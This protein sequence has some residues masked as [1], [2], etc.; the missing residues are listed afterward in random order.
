MPIALL[1]PPSLGKPRATARA[2]LLAQALTNELGEQVTIEVPSSYA[3]LEQRALFG[4]AHMVWAPASVAARLEPTA[5]AIFTVIRSG[6]G[7]YR[8]A[9]IA[10]KQDDVTLERL[11]GLR[12]AWVDPL[13]FGGYLL[14]V[15]HLRKRGID[16]D[17]T[18]VSQHFYGSHPDALAAVVA[19]HAHVSA[20][21]VPGSGEAELR[22]AL[23][24]HVGLHAAELTA[25]AITDGIPNDAM[26]FTSALGPA[27]ADAIARKLFSKD[28]GFRAPTFLLAAME[29]D[30]FVRA[31]PGEYGPLLHLIRAPGDPA[32]QRRSEAPPRRSEPPPPRRT[33]PPPKRS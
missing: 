30:A 17:R 24:M 13:S 2:E 8:S 19:G 1:L 20:V 4:T 32:A 18:F 33:E 9:I 27:R 21:T 16:P 11:N 10:R 29:A 3:D 22:P 6:V 31:R 26:V 5:R 12:A 14:A 25:L 28:G 23:S 15:D 7:T